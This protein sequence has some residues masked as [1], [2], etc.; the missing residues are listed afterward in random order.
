MNTW[1]L[2][3]FL[4]QLALWWKLKDIINFK[5]IIICEILFTIILLPITLAAEILIT[6]YILLKFIYNKGEKNET[7]Y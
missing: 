4:P 3:P 5:L 6:I 1:F 7:K 2:V